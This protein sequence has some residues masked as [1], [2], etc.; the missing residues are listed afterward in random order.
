MPK[1]YTTQQG[2]TWDIISLHVYGSEK[3]GDVLIEANWQ[4]NQRVFFPAGIT[5]KVPDLAQQIRDDRNL[6]PWRRDR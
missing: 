4:E 1:T 5:L 2:D 3:Y 6:P